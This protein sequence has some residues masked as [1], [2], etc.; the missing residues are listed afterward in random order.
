MM[1]VILLFCDS[2]LC[3]FWW[4]KCI[5]T[6]VFMFWI[7]RYGECFGDAMRASLWS[8]AISHVGHLLAA[9]LD[10][11]PDRVCS[12]VSVFC[13]CDTD[14]GGSGAA[15][16]DCRES[17]GDVFVDAPHSFLL[18]HP[19]PSAE[20]LTL[21]AEDPSHCL[22]VSCLFSDSCGDELGGCELARPGYCWG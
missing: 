22:C 8:K 4:I 17:W 7:V 19:I 18:C 20:V 12:D 9:V 2:C 3:N 15:S 6:Y 13:L 10:S 5:N 16:R 14:T 1:M 21:P 11:S